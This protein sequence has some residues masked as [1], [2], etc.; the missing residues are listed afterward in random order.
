MVGH[1]RCECWWYEVKENAFKVV[2]NARTP[3]RRGPITAVAGAACR[4]G[5]RSSLA[6]FAPFQHALL[7][8][9]PCSVLLSVVLSMVCK[10]YC[11]H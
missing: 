8:S 4:V 2:R 9:H 1:V 11:K 6:Q 7:R 5:L 3:P 10:A